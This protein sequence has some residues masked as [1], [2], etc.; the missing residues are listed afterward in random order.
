[1]RLVLL[2]TF[3]S[4]F[5]AACA[6]E[7]E[8]GYQALAIYDY[9]KAK[10]IFYKQL[11]KH[12]AEAGF[13][14]AT[15]YY[16]NDNPFHQLDSAYKYIIIGQDNFSTLPVEK[17]KEISKKLPVRDTL[18]KALHDSICQQAFAKLM[19]KPAVDAAEKYLGTYYRSVYTHRVMCLRDSFIFHRPDRKLTVAG[20]TEYIQTYPQSCYL[21]DAKNL[22]EF[23]IYMETTA[24]KTDEDYLVYLKKYPKGKYISYAKEELLNYYIRYRNAGG[25]FNFIQWYGATYPTTLAWNM[26]LGIEAPHHTK[27]ELENFLKKYPDYPK[28]QELEEEFVFWQTP[29]FQIKKNEKIGFCDSTGKQMIEPI[30]SDANDFS[31]GYAVVQKNDLYGYINKAG[32]TKIDFQYAEASSFTDNVAIVQKEKKYFIIDYSNKILSA[33]YDDIA[34]FSEG[35]AIVKKNNQF[36]AINLTGQ[37]IV[38]PQY[39]MISDFSEGL[40]VFLKNGK[41]GFIDRQ[42]F[43]VI[44]PIYDWVS[45]FKNGQCRAQFNKL[46]GVLNKKGDL[47]IQPEFDLIDESNKGIYLV[48]KNNLYGFAD[49]SGCLLTEIKYAYQPA[50]KTV[51]L[52]DGKYLRLITSKKQELQNLN[53]GKYFQDHVFD[54]IGLP[55]NNFVV[56]RERNKVNI[57]S[58][59]KPGVVKHSL[60]AAYSDGKFWYLENKKGLNVYDLSLDKQLFIL[61]ATH[62]AFFQN[63][64]LLTENED[65]KGLTDLNG[66]EIL[67]MEYDEINATHLPN[68]L[69]VQLNEKGAYFHV[70]ARSFIWKE[71]GFDAL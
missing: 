10:A 55:V 16:R 24:G 43:A 62:A 64:Y 59:Q 47:V 71:E 26:L 15:I 11:K 6:S 21:A 8:K 1:M 53:G 4:S 68:L 63:K 31:E 34:E 42:G 56:A 9:F 28:R 61:E 38:K 70:S 17:K 37:E 54:E 30:Y 33:R 60:I 5:F 41:Y 39:D 49:S 67:P 44:A 36:G 35:M 58:F 22:L 19:Q 20:F 50:L 29:F 12:P 13:G 52:T 51:L 40:A 2:T 48:V 65:G 23:A 46:F 66:N 14:L 7:I 45:S 57:Y 3:L 18:Y 27:A 69:Y 32:K 25:I